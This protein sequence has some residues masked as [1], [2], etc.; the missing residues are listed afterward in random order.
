MLRHLLAVSLLLGSVAH[1][2]PAATKAVTV[3]FQ[4][5]DQYRTA[6]H[7]IPLAKIDRVH[8]ANGE[9]T[10]EIEG[11]RLTPK[12]MTITT[13]K[14]EVAPKDVPPAM[15]VPEEGVSGEHFAKSIAKRVGVEDHHGVSATASREALR[16]SR[17]NH[18]EQLVELKFSHNPGFLARSTDESRLRLGQISEIVK[19]E[20]A[21]YW[22]VPKGGSPIPNRE[23]A[24]SSFPWYSGYA[25]DGLPGNFYNVMH[26]YERLTTHALNDYLDGRTA[27]PGFEQLDRRGARERLTGAQMADAIRAQLVRRMMAEGM[28]TVSWKL[29]NELETR[30]ALAQ[31]WKL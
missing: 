6:T 19:A 26:A 31:K 9:L 4:S 12:H 11:N 7:S 8:G 10:F 3:H 21:S 16:A 28:Q 30:A 18:I 23:R 25:R 24:F 17:L 29:M 22:V 2:K 14:G 27:E 5:E 1:A 13:S 15:A 20:V